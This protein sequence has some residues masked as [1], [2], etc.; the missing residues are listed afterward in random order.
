MALH[1]K[2][3]SVLPITNVTWERR[4]SSTY[5]YEI[6]DILSDN[7]YT[8]GEILSPSLTIIHVDLTDETYYRVRA[9]NDEGTTTTTVYLDVLPR[10]PS[11]TTGQ[12]N[13]YIEKGTNVTLSLNYTSALNVTSVVWEKGIPPMFFY[14]PIDVLNDEGYYGGTIESPSLFITSI[15]LEYVSA[16]YRCKISNLEGESYSSPFYIRVTK[17]PPSILLSSRYYVYTGANVTLE[18]EVNSSLAITNITWE[19]RNISTHM[20]EIIDISSDHRYSG[21]D[22]ML[23]SLSIS[24]IAPTDETYYRVSVTNNDGTTTKEVYIDV[25]LSSPS[26]SLNSRY[27][28]LSGENLT[29]ETNITSVLPITNVTWERR[30]SSTYVYEIIDILSDNRYTGGEILSPSLTIIHVDLTDETYYRVRATNDEG[31]T[32]TTVYLDVLPRLPSITTGQTNF[33]IEKGTNVTLSLN[34]TSALNVTSVVWEKGIP[35]MFFYEPIDVLNDEGYY[36]GTIESPSLFITSISLEYV[37]ALYRCKISN[38]EGE[39][40]SS[41]FYIRV[42]KS[43]PSILLSSRYYVYTGANVTL[44][45]EVNSSLAITNITW[46][47]RNISTHMYEIIDISSDHRY[48]GGD[49]M[50]PS[51]S[52]SDIAPTDET[53]YRVSVTNNDGTTTKEVYIDVVLSSPSISLN[54]RY[55]VLS[56]ENLTLETNITSVLPITNVTWERRNSSTYVYEIIDILSDNRYT[57]GEILSPSLTIIHVDLTDE[58]YY[59]VRATN[60]E[61]TTTTTVY[62]DVLPRLP[63]ITTGQTNFYIEKGTNVT[64]S[65]NYTSALNVTSVVWEKGIPPM[66]FYEP[67]DVLNDEGYYGGTIESPSLFITSISLEYVTALYRCKISNLEGESYS[68]PF[69]IRVTKCKNFFF[70]IKKI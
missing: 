19:R 53:Y 30:N 27:S 59:R 44:E 3:T 7:R 1:L 13:F 18:T 50:L 17:S 36:G 37:S 54:S 62:L 5:V 24:D 47:R 63:S 21:G 15:S 51:L 65:L 55:S 56:G 40:Y 16:L 28:V 34:Y 22:I 52:I 8:G 14:E 49:I 70:N 39:S 69:Y 11:I 48:S 29:L 32:T 46:E 45:T 43:P 42:T 25:V 33:Y 6:I 23:P 9:T 68:S 38:L 67:I 31:T 41:P 57:G 2:N 12:T 26:I 66:F 60:D 10:L 58:T 61:G 4:N 35:P 64:L 20:Y